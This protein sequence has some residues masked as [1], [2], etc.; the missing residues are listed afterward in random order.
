MRQNK[1]AGENPTAP[2]RAMGSTGRKVEWLNSADLLIVRADR[3]EPLVVIPLRLAAE[4]AAKANPSAIGVPFPGRGIA[5][6]CPVCLD[7]S[8]RS[9]QA[10]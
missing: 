7:S 1:P 9:A 5:K 3:K 10:K 2:R 6:R 4:V 8:Q